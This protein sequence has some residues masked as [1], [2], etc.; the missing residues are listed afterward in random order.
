M[1]PRAAGL[2]VRPEHF[3]FGKGLGSIGVPQQFGPDQKLFNSADN[4]FVYLYVTFGIFG[5]AYLL[6]LA[7]RVLS[8]NVRTNEKKSDEKKIDATRFWNLGFLIITFGYGLTTNMFEQ[9]FFCTLLGL[10]FGVIWMA[11]RDKSDAL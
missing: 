7:Q 10:L 1:W 8:T 9:T 11:E 2:L 3:I 6:F 4:L 5:P